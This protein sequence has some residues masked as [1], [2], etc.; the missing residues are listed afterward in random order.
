L[1]RHFPKESSG[2]VR[3]ASDKAKSAPFLDR[4]SF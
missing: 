2:G 1:K 4:R 3:L